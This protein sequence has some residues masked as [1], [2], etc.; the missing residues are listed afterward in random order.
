MKQVKSGRWKE[1]HKEG[2]LEESR[3]RS[4]K[5]VT[6]LGIARVVVYMDIWM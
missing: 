1:L 3:K 5:T 6:S 2:D 4:D